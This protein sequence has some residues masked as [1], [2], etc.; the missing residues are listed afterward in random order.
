MP[1]KILLGKIATY[2]INP[3]IVFGF[4]IATVVFFWGVVRLIWGADGG[5]LEK[6]KSTVF[7]GIVGM[8][9]MFSVYGILRLVLSTFGITYSGLL[10]L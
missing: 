8:F 5:D 1:I 2:I 3:V 7:Y 4:A 9:V 10:G 6:K